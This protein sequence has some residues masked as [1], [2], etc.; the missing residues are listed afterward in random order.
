MVFDDTE[1]FFDERRFKRCDWS[2]CY[3]NVAENKDIPGGCG[4]PV[5]S[6][7]LLCS[8]G[9]SSKNSLLAYGKYCFKRQNTVESSTFGSDLVAMRIAIEMIEG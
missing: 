7:V 6:Y 3:P 5:T 9:L 8:C 4:K 1:P 2:E